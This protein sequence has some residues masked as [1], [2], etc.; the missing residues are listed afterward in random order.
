[1]DKGI[2]EARDKK[3]RKVGWTYGGMAKKRRRK[4]RRGN[5]DWK[6]KRDGGMEMEIHRKR[7]GGKERHNIR[8]YLKI[9]YSNYHLF[10]SIDTKN[11][12]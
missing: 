8:R 2:V 4:R 5:S 6:W 3:G 10:Q 1:M 7:D 12:I 9:L 11:D